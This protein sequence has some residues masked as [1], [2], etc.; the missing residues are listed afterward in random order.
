VTTNT[1]RSSLESL[2]RHLVLRRR[3]PAEFGDAPVLVSP[4]GGLKYL[5]KS[6][7][8]VDPM[9]LSFA[10]EFVRPGTT[11]WDVGAN[12]GLFAFA[13]AGKA[14]VS[15]NVFAIEADPWCA[16]LLRRTANLR[17]AD[18]APVTVISAAVAQQCGLQQFQLAQ[19]SRASNALSG[20]GHS[21]MGGVRELQTVVTLSLDWLIEFLPAPQV[22]KIDVEGAE[23]VVLRGANALF[24]KSRPI[25]LCE[26]AEVNKDEVSAFFHDRGYRL[27]NAEQSGARSPIERATEN[28]LAIPEVAYPGER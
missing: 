2:T 21:Q 27:F 23:A 13:A 10:S 4:S 16:Q 1:L 26:V 19:R 15:G 24:A 28:T 14:G 11:V 20:F 17:A 25:V 18:R 12:V 6:L 22:L 9:L 5:V 3:L 8:A 7:A